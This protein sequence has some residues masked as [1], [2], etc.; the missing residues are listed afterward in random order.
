MDLT[1]TK[2][3]KKMASQ[4]RFNMLESSWKRWKLTWTNIIQVTENNYACESFLFFVLF[5][6]R[7]AW[8]FPLD[9]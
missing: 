8:F 4:N 2:R 7:S 1:R 6:M 9:F 5:Y 3:G